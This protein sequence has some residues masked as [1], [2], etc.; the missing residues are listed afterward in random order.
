MPAVPAVQWFDRLVPS[1]GHTDV[2][3][4]LVESELEPRDRFIVWQSR[5]CA[6]GVYDSADVY[7]RI[8]RAQTRERGSVPR[9]HHEV[10]TEGPQRL[11]IDI[12]ANESQ[13]RAISDWFASAPVVDGQYDDVPA[14]VRDV[15]AVADGVG[16]IACAWSRATLAII[17]ACIDVHM[18]L[19]REDPPAVCVC[20]SIDPNLQ[21]WSRHV[22]F[23]Q[24]VVSSSTNAREF[25][26][27]V[28][29]LLATPLRAIVDA[30]VYKRTQNFRLVGSTKHGEQRPKRIMTAHTFADTII[31]QSEATLRDIA[32][33]PVARVQDPVRNGTDEDTV[34]PQVLAL[35][36]SHGVL[37]ANRFRSCRDGIYLFDRIAPSHCDACDR[38][39]D[40]DHTVMMVVGPVDTAGHAHVYLKCRRTRSNGRGA[41]VGTVVVSTPDDDVDTVSA[42]RNTFAIERALAVARAS[43]GVNKVFA[44]A[45]RVEY[46]DA[47]MRPFPPPDVAD[48]LV[49]HAPMKLGKTKQLREYLNAHFPPR[50]LRPYVIRFVSFRQT[51]SANIKQ[52]FPD[53]TLYSD[54]RAD[55]PLDMPRVIVQVESLHRLEI[56]GDPPDL[57]ILD[58]SE[59]ILEQFDSGLLKRMPVAISKFIYLL[60]HARVVVC[61]DAYVSTRTERVLAGIRARPCTYVRNT[62]RNCTDSDVY[63]CPDKY[64]WIELIDSDIAC[65]RKCAIVM[66]SLTEANAM[67]ALLRGRHRDRAIALYSSETPQALKREHFADV[68]A[69]WSQYDVLMYTPT[70][71]AGVSFEQ[72]HFA[73]VYGYFTSM[74]CN[75]ATCIQMLGRIRDVGMRQTFLYL[76]QEPHDDLPTT[77]DEILERFYGRRA[78]LFSKYD[79][80]GCFN[81]YLHDGSVVRHL[82][83][84]FEIWVENVRARNLSRTTFMQMLLEMLLEPGYRV[85]VLT[86]ISALLAPAI[87]CDPVEAGDG[88]VEAPGG[89]EDAPADE[90]A[91]REQHRKQLHADYLGGRADSLKSRAEVIATAPDIDYDE[92]TRV[93][94]LLMRGADV[95]T[96]EMASLRKYQLRDQYRY[97]GANVDSK[98]VQQYADVRVRAWFANLCAIGHGTDRDVQQIGAVERTL[99]MMTRADDAYDAN[100]RYT[101][102]RHRLCVFAMRMCGWNDGLHVAPPY[103][104]VNV[105]VADN[106]ARGVCTLIRAIVREFEMH[107]VGIPVPTGAHE[108]MTIR[109]QRV[110]MLIAV[111]NKALMTMYGA[112]IV[113]DKQF[114]DMYTLRACPRFAYVGDADE[115][116]RPRIRLRE[117]YDVDDDVEIPELEELDDPAHEDKNVLIMRD[118]PEFV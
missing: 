25:C 88:A 74:S 24:S 65:G 37:R 19:W 91:V 39:H 20:E 69:F 76:K 99:Y 103:V 111:A 118:L 60:Q 44:G 114:S 83:P 93:Q 29:A 18:L 6:Y 89:D 107:P 23:S 67:L 95:S 30:G 40:R 5:P 110:R 31:A 36:E 41:V 115:D 80:I 26:T 21:K 100:R 48:T 73:R 64:A 117:V 10:I 92:Y 71:S 8:A 116:P 102:N 46:D 15:L 49:V 47:Q 96:G 61:M 72:V 17:A 63:V 16:D 27:Q 35:A 109:V 98:F 56:D 59:S 32:A 54:V 68:N 85:Q 108:S 12:D 86:D 9:Y 66:S 94:A 70:V 28:C 75:A 33:A 45:N 13:I 112:A 1:A 87:P 62:H 42:T 52:L 14:D 105:I 57:V 34:R 82:T 7:M 22:I 51:F 90:V 3:T 4:Y 79:E 53:F 113:A 55:A 43:A 84:Y 78:A 101:Y 106:D 81:E 2:E 11:R 58:E 104:H 38:V 50:R 97:Y 77:R